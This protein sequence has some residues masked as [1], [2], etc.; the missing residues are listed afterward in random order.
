M[1]MHKFPIHL[2]IT[3]PDKNSLHGSAM[4]DIYSYFI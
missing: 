3:A 4:M 1:R 2:S